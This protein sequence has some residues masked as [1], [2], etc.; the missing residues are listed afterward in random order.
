MSKTH[1]KK[2]IN[3]KFAGAYSLTEGEQKT[4]TI[5][6]VYAEKVKGQGGAEETCLVVSFVEDFKP[7]IANSGNR[8]TIASLYGN[9]IEDWQ[10]QRI[11]LY[12]QKEKWGGTWDH[13][14]RIQPIRPKS[15]DAA[16]KSEL[17]GKIAD[18]LA[19]L[20]ETVAEGWKKRLKAAAAMNKD[21]V[22]NLT[23][24]LKLINAEL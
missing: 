20:P 22:I 12:L 6:S 8:K 1:F 17:K 18:A 21:T 16:K 9:Y 7:I 2:L 19:S 13:I 3:P 10:G 11:T 24:T 4:L 5:K 23:K 14:L 15:G